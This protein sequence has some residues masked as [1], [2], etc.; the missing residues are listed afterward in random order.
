VNSLGAMDRVLVGR[1]GE[2]AA[3]AGLL[4]HAADWSGLHRRWNSMLQPGAVHIRGT[5]ADEAAAAHKKRIALQLMD[6]LRAN[7]RADAPVG[8]VQPAASPTDS[9]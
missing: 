6:A 7:V 9:C 8:S 1:L 2:A 4:R 3:A 5:A